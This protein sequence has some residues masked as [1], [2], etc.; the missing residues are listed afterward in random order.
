MN[1]W[2]A[3]PRTG[4]VALIFGGLLW[5][6]CAEKHE[7]AAAPTLRPRSEIPVPPA[8]V[9][10]KYAVLWSGHFVADQAVQQLSRS[11]PYDRITLERSPCFGTCPVYKLHLYRDGT[12]EYEGIQHTD[13][14]GRHT[15]K[16]SLGIFARLCYLL[17]REKFETLANEYSADWTDDTTCTVSVF[18]DGKRVKSVS[19]YGQQGPIGLWAIQELID[20]LAA[21]ISWTSPQVTFPSKRK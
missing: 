12:A 7:A 20:G 14:L 9:P 15:G 1:D 8:A 17:E 4:L 16:I 11:L 18:K 2:D 10:E 5:G 19:D 3:I 21:E 13:K 6:G